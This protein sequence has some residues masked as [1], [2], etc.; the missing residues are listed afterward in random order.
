[1]NKISRVGI[2]TMHRINNYGS[3]LQTYATQHILNSLG[4]Y[5]EVIDYVFPNSYHFHKGYPYSPTSWKHKIAKALNLSSIG[6]KA[7]KFDSFRKK[8]LRLSKTYNT[9]EELVK[10]PPTYDLYIT[11]SDQVWNPKHM[12]GD[13][14][15]LLGFTKEKERRISYASSFACNE[16]PDEYKS[17]YIK[18]LSRY[19]NISVRETNGSN[20]LK[21]LL[22]KESFVALDPTL[23]LS[24][25]DWEKQFL[26]DK[27]NP[28]H[29][30]RYI[31]LYM[32]GYAFD[33]TPYIY[34]LVKY[35]QEKY[36]LEVYSFSPIPKEFK[37]DKVHIIKE[38]SPRDFLQLFQ[39]AECVITS[40]F[41]GTAF[42]VN[43]GCSLYSIINDKNGSD[44]RQSSLLKELNLENCAIPKNTNLDSLPT[45]E[46]NKTYKSQEQLNALRKESISFLKNS[47]KEPCY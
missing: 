1:M 3:V 2:I 9:Y 33:P 41:H 11:G 27:K 14:A 39:E 13:K 37:L 16:I 43:F 32:L 22:K 4:L 44:D 26:L 19:Q 5:C 6:R 21:K 35:I 12:K 38:A 30:K 29:E 47:I 34:H 36:Q 40:S 15:F 42:A 23:L 20:L 31:L 45:I 24:K 10:M 46:E 18:L 28:Y 8:N 7:K 25:Y 17:T